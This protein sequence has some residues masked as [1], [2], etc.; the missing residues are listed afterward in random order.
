MTEMSMNHIRNE[1]RLV[2]PLLFNP[3]TI[4]INTTSDNIKFYIN[5]HDIM[6][7]VKAIIEIGNICSNTVL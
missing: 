7:T 2:L 3:F 4:F 1:G 6:D 5:C